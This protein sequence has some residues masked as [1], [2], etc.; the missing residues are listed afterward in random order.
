MI[1]FVYNEI[2]YLPHTIDYYKKNGCEIYVID[3]MSNDGTW[4]WLQENRIQSHRVDTGESF[5][6]RILQKEIMKTLP[7]LNPDWVVYAGADLYFIAGIALKDYI[8]KV[9]NMGY[10]QLSMMCW[11]AFNTGEKPGTPLPSHYFHALPWKHVV[12]ISKYDSSYSMNG[13]FVSIDNAKCYEGKHSMAIN[14]GACKPTEEQIVKL[15]RRKKAWAEGMRAQQGRHFLAGEKIGWLRNKKDLNDLRKVAEYRY[16]LRVTEARERF[17][18]GTYDKLYSKSSSYKIPY[19]DTVYYKVW[20]YI[21]GRLNNSCSILEMGCG[22][23]QLANL[24]FDTGFKNY[25]GIDFSSVAIR[26]AIERVPEFKFVQA[27]L[28]TFD[29]K[30]YEKHVLISTETFEHMENDLELLKRFH[31]NRIIFSV[32]NFMAESHYR[33]YDSVEY[34]RRYYK[35]V[36]Q[37]S[38]IKPFLI[39]SRRIIFVVDA[40]VLL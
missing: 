14:Y 15:K 20:K 32:P 24:L 4:E 12:M 2:K 35:G 29:F 33:T 34:I 19:Q 7:R 38:E 30:G 3:N 5:D 9:E 22:S 16:I 36:L 37:I 39:G 31:G 6:L 27:D 1:C 25:L 17:E 13:D 21:A 40:I 23:G 28:Q 18:P 26:M 10:N 8:L 11:S